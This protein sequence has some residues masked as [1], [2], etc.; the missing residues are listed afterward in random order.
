MITN[1]VSYLAYFELFLA[2]IEQVVPEVNF[3]K[4]PFECTSIK[5]FAMS[6]HNIILSNC[7][8]I[9]KGNSLLISTNVVV[10]D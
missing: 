7:K 3:R 6:I 2:L 4:W 9:V 8:V 10:N 5:L 1:K